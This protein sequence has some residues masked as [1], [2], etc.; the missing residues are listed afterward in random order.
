[1]KIKRS[2]LEKAKKQTNTMTTL[3]FNYEEANSLLDDFIDECVEASDDYEHLLEMVYDHA[4]SLVDIYYSDIYEST[5]KFSEAIDL[6]TE[7]LGRPESIDKEIQQGQLYAYD[8]LFRSFVDNLIELD[9]G[10]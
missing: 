3:V 7:E 2:T 6:A 8:L 5:N 9:G 1:M 10:A 4:E